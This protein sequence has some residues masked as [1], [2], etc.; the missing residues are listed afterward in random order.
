[1]VPGRIRDGC[2]SQAMSQLGFAIFVCSAVSGGPT[3]LSGGSAGE[4]A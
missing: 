4:S 1:M 3:A 2:I